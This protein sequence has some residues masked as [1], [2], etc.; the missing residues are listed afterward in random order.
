MSRHV[1][2]ADDDEAILEVVTMVLEDE[3]FTV[4]VL[5]DDSVITH[6][7][8]PYPDVMLLDIWMSG[9]DGRDIVKSLKASKK[10]RSIPVILFSANRDCA[11]IAKEVGADDYLLKPFNI[12]ELVDKIKLHAGSK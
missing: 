12:E 2:I 6:L 4:T 8:K 3:G 1:M 10:L 9:Q 5:P 7:K 11:T